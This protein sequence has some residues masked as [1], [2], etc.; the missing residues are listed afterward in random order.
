MTINKAAGSSAAGDSAA[1]DNGTGAAPPAGPGG[2]R[3]IASI[4]G[5]AS[6]IDGYAVPDCDALNARL[7]ADVLAWRAVDPGETSSNHHG[8]HSSR[9]LF[10]RPE[11]SFQELARHVA[12]A[13]IGRAHV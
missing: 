4:P 7:A 5:F 6:Y 2:P 10:S 3:R 9:N 8:W 13:Q 11:A 1:G 12:S